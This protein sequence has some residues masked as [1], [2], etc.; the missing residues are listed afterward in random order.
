MLRL[1]RAGVTDDLWHLVDD[2]VTNRTAAIRMGSHTSDH[3][4]V[5][6]G[7]GQGAVLSGFLFNI[8]IN[9]LAAAI[10]RACNGVSCDS[11]DNSLR[12][13]V[14]LYADDV[15]ILCENAADLQRALDAAQA[16][17]RSWRFHFGIGP[18]KSA[19]M[20]FGNTG[21]RSRVPPF[22]LS[23]QVLP[24]V[25]SYPYLG[26]VFHEKLH[27]KPHVDY[28]LKRGECKMAACLSW[29]NAE[30]LPVSFVDSIFQTYVRPSA[31]FGLEFLTDGSQLKRFQTRLL[32]WGKRLL[33]WPQ[34][35][36]GIVVQGQL[37]W[38]SASTIRPM[39]AASL[40]ARLLSFP[41]NCFAAQLARFATAHSR[42]WQS[43]LDTELSAAGVQHPFNWGIHAGC[44]QQ[45]VTQWLS[46]VKQILHAKFCADYVQEVR[47]SQSLGNF[48]LWQPSPHLH[49]VVY[50]RQS[51]PMDTRLWGLVRC[52]HHAFAD[53]RSAR[54][55]HASPD[56]PCRFCAIG[57][58]TLEH[59]LVACPAH[60]QSRQRWYFSTSGSVPLTLHTLFS[61]DPNV[62][63]TRD[64]LRNIAFVG[65]VCR[66]ADACEI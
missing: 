66:A 30:N 43:S 27:W 20:V 18:S 31:C 29:T 55:R 6:D 35:A 63:R 51:C 4:E 15:V 61:T 28:V 62:N 57:R 47:S 19:V 60:S 56:V 49:P 12:V 53:G 22:F 38:H 44:S 2:F 32:Q 52:G 48:L 45:L 46:S 10:K 3:W 39:Q 7:I 14:L 25:K 26:I 21:S 13:K 8:L 58:D 59:A 64:I 5:E 11:D 17:A 33:M 1:R 9:G 24:R 36:P 23:G 40:W 41:H 42:S 50:G 65:H 37:A 34:G 54:H 16:W